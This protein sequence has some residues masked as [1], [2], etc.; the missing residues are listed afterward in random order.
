VWEEQFDRAVVADLYGEDLLVGIEAGVYGGVGARE[1][2]FAG[3]G[4]LFEGKFGQALFLIAGILDVIFHI[5]QLVENFA[6]YV[7]E[8]DGEDLFVDGVIIEQYAEIVVFVQEN[9]DRMNVHLAL[10]ISTK[11]VVGK[12]ES[13]G[14]V[15]GCVF[16]AIGYKPA[17]TNGAYPGGT[18]SDG[19]VELV[20]VATFVV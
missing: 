16:V 20:E 10:D 5:A 19:R 7:G 6:V 12:S 18:L 14:T 13:I 1:V 9:R 15:C 8:I 3:A 2:V 11:T 4:I 17:V